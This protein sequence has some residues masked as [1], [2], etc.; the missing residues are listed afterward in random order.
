[1]LSILILILLSILFSFL[2]YNELSLIDTIYFD[3]DDVSESG[4]S[5]PT[6]VET[7]GNT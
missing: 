5:K 3:G 1:M 4:S 2:G 6:T 7:H